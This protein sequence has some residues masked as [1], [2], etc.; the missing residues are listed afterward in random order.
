[1]VMGG[2]YG[3][4]GVLEANLRT[5]YFCAEDHNEPLRI[6]LI[7]DQKVKRLKAC[8]NT[9]RLVR[10]I[11]EVDKR[12]KRIKSYKVPLI[13]LAGIQRKVE[14]G[15]WGQMYGCSL[16]DEM[17]VPI[18]YGNGTELDLRLPGQAMRAGLPLIFSLDREAVRKLGDNDYSLVLLD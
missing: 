12:D 17:I 7:G 15:I 18:M 2:I 6:L 1:V 9:Q 3:H 10:S 4:L 16:D 5:K 11:L 14:N 13:R 8:K